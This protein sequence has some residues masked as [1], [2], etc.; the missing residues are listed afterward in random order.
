MDRIFVNCYG[1]IL[2]TDRAGMRRMLT[3]IAD[4]RNFDPL[5][6]GKVVGKIDYSLA[7]IDALEA[8]FLLQED[9]EPALA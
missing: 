4:K 8:Q 3:A 6:F 1:N 9:F 7:H 2:Q 5:E